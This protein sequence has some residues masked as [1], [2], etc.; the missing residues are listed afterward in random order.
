[1]NDSAPNC[2]VHPPAEPSGD[3]LPG[4]LHRAL[5]H[6]LPP[7][8]GVHSPEMSCRTGKC[9]VRQSSSSPRTGNNALP[10]EGRYDALLD[11]CEVHALVHARLHARTAHC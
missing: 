10:R 11:V 5:S 3:A 2:S 9:S 6:R 7:L 4:E 1:M 8:E